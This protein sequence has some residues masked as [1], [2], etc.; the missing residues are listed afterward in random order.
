M[1]A[2]CT[3]A[4]RLA[5]LRLAGYELRSR[6]DVPYRVVLNEAIELAKDFGAEG[7]ADGSGC[8]ERGGADEKCTAGGGNAGHDDLDTQ[9]HTRGDLSP[10]EPPHLHFAHAA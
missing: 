10:I 1:S 4:A 6:P 7:G 9:Q 5:V 3:R 8:G 2:A